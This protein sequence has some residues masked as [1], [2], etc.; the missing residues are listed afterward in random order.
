MHAFDARVVKNI[1]VGL[2]NNGDKY[3]TLD[4]TERN[5]TN[6]D[7]MIKN[8]GKYFAIAGVMGGLDTEITENTKNIIM[9]PYNNSEVKILKDFYERNDT[10]E[11]QEN[12]LIFYDSTYMPNILQPFD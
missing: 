6:E 1:E 9:R 10:E 7:L 2:A 8:G 11:N 4:G 5:L 12:S 3:T